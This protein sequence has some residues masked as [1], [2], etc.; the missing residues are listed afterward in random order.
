MLDVFLLSICTSHQ[1]IT[2]QCLITPRCSSSLTFASC[3]SSRNIRFHASPNFSHYC[4]PHCAFCVNQIQVVCIDTHSSHS[5]KT[6][7]SLIPG[8]ISLKDAMRPL[9]ASWFQMIFSWNLRKSE[10]P[11]MSFKFVIRFLKNYKSA[12]PLSQDVDVLWG[13]L[14]GGGER[15]RSLPIALEFRMASLAH[16]LQIPQFTKICL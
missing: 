5:P 14:G 8:C 1:L 2:P 13:D 7:R 16:H 4:N 15:G 12:K 9:K 10:T 3:L 6:C 11:L